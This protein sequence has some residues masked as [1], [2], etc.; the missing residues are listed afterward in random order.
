MLMEFH[1]KWNDISFLL[2]E[3]DKIIDIV[4]WSNQGTFWY[5]TSIYIFD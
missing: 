1:F 2:E 5:A 4:I 3:F